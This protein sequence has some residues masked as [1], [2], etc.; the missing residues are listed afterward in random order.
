MITDIDSRVETEPI[1]PPTLVGL[2]RYFLALGATGFGGPV[3]LVGYMQRDLVDRRR[4]FAAPQFAEGLALAQLSPGPLAAQLAMYLGWL[5]GGARG[6]TLVGLAF[7][8]PP[9]LM[10]LALAA[11]YVAAGELQWLQR[12]FVGVG[13]GVVCI[14]ARSVMKLARLTLRADRLLW[15]VSLVSAAVVI[16]TRRELVWL[17]FAGGLVCAALRGPRAAAST[18]ALGAPWLLAAPLVLTSTTLLQLLAFFVVAGVTVF[19]SGFAIIPFL[20]SGVV[21]QRHWLNERQFLDAIAVAM[22]TPGPV[23]ITAA[24]IGYLVAGSLGAVAASVGVFAP[25]WLLVLLLAPR[26]SSVVKR[27]FVRPFVDG[28]T[29]GATGAL[30]GAAVLLAARVLVDWRSLAIAVAAALV[31]VLRVRIPEPLLIAA[32]GLVGVLLI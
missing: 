24:F 26:F 6:A 1:A 21:E 32:A 19:G 7:I 29:A 23:V 4:W 31:L 30:A 13:A 16:V 9:F 20:Y 14:L 15:G 3:A 25:C 10:V 28:V 18:L 12:A 2:V 27:P 8:G 5:Q 22:I 17:L 11:A